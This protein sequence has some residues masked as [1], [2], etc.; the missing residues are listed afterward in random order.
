[1][2]MPA[3]DIIIDRAHLACYADHKSIRR[4][5]LKLLYLGFTLL[6]VALPLGMVA[7]APPG[8]GP[9]LAGG[10]L[11]S[12][13]EAAPESD[14]D[15]NSDPGVDLTSM[16][17]WFDGA[18]QDTLVIA[19]DFS[20][21][22][23]DLH[24]MVAL[25]KN[26]DADG[27]EQDPFEFLIS[28]GH[29][30]KP[31]YVFTYKYSAQ[32]YSDLRRW[33][34]GWEFWYLDGEFWSP[35]DNV[36]GFNKNALGMVTREGSRV[37]FR[38]PLGAIGDISPGD[39][40]RLQTYVTQE[41]S[42]QKYNALDSNPHDVTNDMVPD[43]GNWWDTA[44]TIVALSEYA[45]FEVPAFGAPPL[46]SEAAASPDTVLPGEDVLFSTRV[47]DAGGG[48]GDVYVDLSSLGGD[49]DAALNDDGTGGDQQAGDGVFSALF[50]LPEDA[51][52]G[53]H[54]ITFAATD[55]TGLTMRTV[56]ASLVVSTDLQIFITV[57]DAAGDDHGPNQTDG[58]GNPVPGLYYFY[59]TNQVFKM[60]IYDL[61]KVD[62]MLDGP[63][64]V[65]RVYLADVLTNSESG[66]WG[67]PYPDVMCTSPNK[68]QLN[69]P[70]IDVYIDSEEGSG[71]TTGF[72]FRYVNIAARDA[73]EYGVAAE[74][75]WV[76]L[77]K[78][79]NSNSSADWAILKHPS[80]IYIC[81]D[82]VEEYVDV[83]IGLAEIG[84]PSQAEIKTWDFIITMASHDGDSNDSN[85]GGIRS[86]NAATAEWQ[87]GG[88]R[89]SEAGRE[90]DPN[91]VDVATVVG[92]GK[93]AGSSQV[94]MLDYTTPEALARFDQG[95]HSCILEATSD[96]PGAIFGTVT[97]D[98]TLDFTTVATVEAYRDGD[99]IAAAQTAP[100][101]GAY[102]IRSLPDGTYDVMGS[103]P[104][105]GERTVSDLV[106][107]GGTTHEGI[108]FLLPKIPGAIFGTVSLPG[109]AQDVRVYALDAV[110][111]ELSGDRVAVVS[112]G[113]GSFQ[114]LAVEDGNHTL[115]AQARGYAQY[116]SVLSISRDTLDVAI[117]T[118]LAQATRYVF[119]DSIVD[120][121]HAD[122]IGPDAT[123]GNEIYSVSVSRSLPDDDVYF[124]ADLMFEPRDDD[125]SAAIYDQAA[126]DSIPV[127]ATL[128][129]P[130]VPHRGNVIFAD[131]ADTSGALAD[132]IIVSE[133]F[134]D[135]VGR[136]YVSDDSIEVL[137][138]EISKGERSGVVE[139]G[140]G[141]LEPA[142]VQLDIDKSEIV[143]GGTDRI[144]VGIQ[145]VDVRGNFVPEPDVGIRLEA[146]SGNPIFEPDADITDANGFFT[147]ALYGFV[148]GAV[149]FTAVIEPGEFEGLAADTVDVV[150][151][152]GPAASISAALAPGAV[153]LDGES[154]LT[155][156]VIDSYGN[157]VPEQ[158]VQIS[159]SVSPEGLLET[160]ESP[161]FTDAGGRAVSH[162]VAGDSYG[163]VT[164]EP[165][166]VYPAE[167]VKLSIDARLV[168]VDEEAP[169]SDPEHNA[170]PGVDLTTMFGW[171]DEESLTVAL[172]FAS[173][174]ND[175]H[176]MV[177]VERNGD[178]EGG[179]QDP[180][181]FPIFY[182]HAL[183][184]D[185]VF[186]YKYSAQDYSDLRRWND[187]WEFWYLDGAFWSPDDNPGSCSSSH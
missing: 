156:Q 87:L 137:L 61:R 158:S 71:S 142:R 65:V 43:T 50:T 135:G 55:A 84:N 96:Y 82:H 159:I 23:G 40:L 7:A 63:Y 132:D 53:L 184:P 69:S 33:N 110:S 29:A 178:A 5:T 86:V 105:Y 80:E 183:K 126:L 115:I 73:W 31:D 38:F 166:S 169:E 92:E 107:D 146:V 6:L 19:L 10:R 131:R 25:E 109:P 48:I 18:G 167:V 153:Q 39:T 152:P 13:D 176:V 66:N 98:D 128:L 136:F 91:I 30:L 130:S 46:L 94:A 68:G 174:W 49:P 1:M 70:K 124:F 95:S 154:D 157:A 41:P 116:D 106:I 83:R 164:L 89:N 32:D 108:D 64:L 151:H 58:Q 170:D 56:V 21:T 125:G 181:V 17:A 111:G 113:S 20:S 100:G 2:H 75:W 42:G 173:P 44:T 141:E 99:L 36:P 90:R 74:G 14:P 101:G 139:V 47:D 120:V 52:G 175:I 150:F 26:G 34:D 67:A 163:I 143:V 57:E 144:E 155:L 117:S 88:G 127:A 24:L 129:D 138:V 11:V 103:A 187:G 9:L 171:S 160:V 54:Q 51:S 118:G 16:Y 97:L 161:V 72:P 114:I 102:Q 147:S 140:V 78:S 172:D 62:F 162:L 77:V 15:H 59:P 179:V 93:P 177:V 112:G 134:D 22:W 76:G 119:I 145:L 121:A 60:G 148:S 180:F 81:N 133:M 37:L 12:V 123:V 79:N 4:S 45:V 186:T 28:Y 8:T 27:G 165:T 104:S 85:L 168:S 122:I 35:N 182:G 3:G 185:Y 149:R